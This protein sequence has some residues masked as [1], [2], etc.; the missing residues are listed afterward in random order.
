[1]RRF[2]ASCMMFWRSRPLLPRYRVLPPHRVHLHMCI[3]KF[4]SGLRNHLL[5]CWSLASYCSMVWKM[6]VTSTLWVQETSSGAQSR[7]LLQ[8]QSRM[9]ELNASLGLCGH[10]YIICAPPLARAVLAAQFLGGR[11]HHA[12]AR[13]AV[14]PSHHHVVQC[15]A[16]AYF[17]TV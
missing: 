4:T 11:Y 15:C 8:V 9:H 7:S 12:Q 10:M 6:P 2:C 1:M 5:Q 13:G 14:T 16:A 3:L 17:R